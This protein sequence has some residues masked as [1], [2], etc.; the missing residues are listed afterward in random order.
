MSTTRRRTHKQHAGRITPAA[1]A[2]FVACNRLTPHR[3]LRLP[4]W[5][6]SPLDAEGASP[7]PAD[8][9]GTTA[10]PDSVALRAE[11]LEAA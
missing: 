3:L 10:W 2:A 6:S 9:V 4:R 11:L 5:Q 8:A 7:W 1:V